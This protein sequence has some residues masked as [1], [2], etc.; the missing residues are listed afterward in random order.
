VNTIQVNTSPKSG[1]VLAGSIVQ[2]RRLA[3]AKGRDIYDDDSDT[4]K[5]YQYLGDVLRWRA[6][7]SP[8]HVLYTVINSK[9]QETQKLTCVQLHKKAER[10][11]CLLIDKGQLNSGDHVALM[12]AP[13]TDLI[14]AFYAC[15]YVGL[16]PVPIRPP[17]SQNIQ[18]TLTTVKLVTDMAKA[19]AVLTTAHVIKLLKSKEANAIIDA[20]QWPTLLDI[21]ESSKKK[22]SAFYKPSSSERI[23]YLD[24]SVSTTGVLSGIKV[25]HGCSTAACRSI[26]L[27]CELYPSREVVLCLDPYSGLGFVLWCLNSVY[28]GHHSILVPPGEVEINPCIWLATVSHFKVRDTFCSYSVME[29]CTKGLRNSVLELKPNSTISQP[30]FNTLSSY[31]TNGTILRRYLKS[32][33]INLSCVRTCAI[34]AEERPRIQLTTAFTKLFQSLGLPPRSVSTTFGCRVN[35][36]LCL[37]GA[38]DPDPTCVYVDQRALRNDRVTIVE[39]GSPHSVCLLESGKLLPGV[40]VVIGNPETKGQCADS[41]LG[42][43]WVQSPHNANGYFNTSADA[44]LLNEHFESRLATGDSSVVYART[45]FLGFVRRTDAIASNGEPHDAI[46]IVGSLDET[47]MIRGMRY[48]PIDIELSVLRSHKKICEC[49]CF[50]WT[51]LLVAVVELDGSESEALDLVPLV[52]NCVLEEHYLIVGVVVVVDPG[53]VPINSRG[54]KQRMHLRDGFLSDLLD[55]IYVAYNM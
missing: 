55:P 10:V 5:K 11:G 17:N 14:V 35:V 29:T 7:T 12:F 27:A 13:G 38:S 52:T 53:V 15:L 30:T 43:I 16:V 8:D 3:E 32:R 41:H 36:A 6:T 19:K 28:S 9:A 46:Y 48:H 2:G 40:K 47:L 21:D 18:T 22:L 25:S 24:F 1:A 20:K 26:K 45:G 39:K 34:I 54:E 33:G 49:A 50:T 51:N 4:A 37:Q 42:E 44:E 23:C 31:D